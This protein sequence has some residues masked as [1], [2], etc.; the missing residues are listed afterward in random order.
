M[1]RFIDIPLEL[2][3]QIVNLVQPDD[4]DSLVLTS[5]HFYSALSL[6]LVEHRALRRQYT[7]VSH[8][9]KAVPHSQEELSS[10]H[11][12]PQLLKTIIHRPSIGF[13]IKKIVLRGIETGWFT[14][15]DDSS[16]YDS[17]EW[18]LN[19]PCSEE[20]CDLFKRAASQFLLLSPDDVERPEIK[21][22]HEDIDGGEHAALLGLIMLHCP[23]LTILDMDNRGG[24]A[25]AVFCLFHDINNSG[26]FRFLSQLRCVH[27]EQS[28]GGHGDWDECITR[29]TPLL[30]L[31][32]MDSIEACHMM[33][34]EHDYIFSPI[35][36]RGSS[37]RFI[38]FTDCA[39][40]GRWFFEFLEGTKQLKSLTV[41]RTIVDDFWLR[42]ALLTFARES[43]QHLSLRSNSGKLE[44]D[45]ECRYIGLLKPFTALQVIEL[46]AMALKSP[47]AGAASELEAHLPPSLQSL[48]LVLGEGSMEG[49]G[50]KLETLAN[51]NAERK[52]L[53][54][55]QKVALIERGKNETYRERNPLRKVRKEFERQGME[56]DIA[57][58]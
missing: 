10:V 48:T 26:D 50:S 39:F 8:T 35:P 32:A 15:D 7:V 52:V 47:N 44:E 14:P 6:L 25:N 29:L 12:L 40:S 38:T 28:E 53:P 55:L 56:F 24:H 5:K 2:V 19:P 54:Y 31:P 20:D 46:D 3:H 57:K 33:G 36:Y 22:W 1:A 9:A 13:Y 42:A 34:G 4:I 30:A 41:H 58:Y 45:Q 23:N 37:I 21:Q 18:V 43:L 49:L 51:A 17:Y 11:L 16:F 27:V